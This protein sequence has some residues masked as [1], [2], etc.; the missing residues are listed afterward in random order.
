MTRAN[1][2]RLA[3]LAVIWGA[4]FLFIKLALA[5]LGPV[6]IVL[7]RLVA[8]AAVLLAFVALRRQTLPRDARLLGHLALMA[9]VGSIIPFFLFAWGEQ[10]VT[11]GLA[12]VLNGTTPLFTLG[13][14]VAALPEERL[15]AARALGLVLGFAGVVLV[16]G[17][18]DANPLTSSVPGQLACLGAAACYGVGFVYT[19]RFIAQ[20]GQSPL[21]LA[22]TQI[23][24][25][26][27]LLG[28][29]SPVVARGDV[30]LTPV[31]LA[32]VA[33]LGALGTG[34]AFVLY[35]RLIAEAGATSASVV[36]YLVPVVAVALGAVL[37]GE[38]VTWNV[39]AGAAVVILGIAIAEGRLARL[40]PLEAAAPR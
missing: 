11:S 15:T 17:P 18:W 40:R 36:T 24:L 23:T 7:A 4:S 30:A 38:P 20:R 26:A 10:R 16:V 37:L 27:L 21:A 28:A 25:A 13:V 1:L 34:I 2:V 3:V 32:S 9:V 22:A 8:G 31:V 5:G 12:G 14:A 35:Y 19:R 6:Q 33:T 39:F 29:A